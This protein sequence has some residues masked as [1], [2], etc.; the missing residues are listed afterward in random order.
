MLHCWTRMLSKQI[1]VWFDNVIKHFIRGKVW[2]L[3]Y[4]SLAFTNIALACN[5]LLMF[6]WLIGICLE[7]GGLNVWQ[8]LIMTINKYLCLRALTGQ[9]IMLVVRWCCRFPS[10]FISLGKGI[11][12]LMIIHRYYPSCHKSEGS[13]MDRCSFMAHKHLKLIFSSAFGVPCILSSY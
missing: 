8:L 5:L 11:V 7:T 3:G 6:S 12:S 13:D 9:E 10:R 1:L 2:F 4:L